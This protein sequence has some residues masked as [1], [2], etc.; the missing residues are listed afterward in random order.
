MIIK[1]DAIDADMVAAPTSSA[2]DLSGFISAH[3][4]P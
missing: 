1:V 4:Q 3:Q 2:C